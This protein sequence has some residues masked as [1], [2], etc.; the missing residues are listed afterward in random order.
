MKLKQAASKVNFEVHKRGI[1]KKVKAK[2]S[3]MW[4]TIDKVRAPGSSLAA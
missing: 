4:T 2:A 1:V 3:N